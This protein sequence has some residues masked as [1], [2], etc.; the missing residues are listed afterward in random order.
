MLA[1]TVPFRTMGI[2]VSSNK[3]FSTFPLHWLISPLRKSEKK[4]AIAEKLK[5]LVITR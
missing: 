4:E 1:L 2:I 3:T 5:I